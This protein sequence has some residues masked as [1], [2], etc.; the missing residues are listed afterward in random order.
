MLHTFGAVQS[1]ETAS[2]PCPYAFT[3]SAV[4]GYSSVSHVWVYSHNIISTSV[5][6]VSCDD[7]KKGG[8]DNGNINPGFGPYC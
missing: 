7:Y 5:A 3:L 4:K 1:I 2:M 8:V 6:P